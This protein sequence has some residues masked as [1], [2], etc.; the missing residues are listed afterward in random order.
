MSSDIA[1]PRVLTVR[2]VVS[3]TSDATAPAGHGHSARRMNMT[4]PRT[5][6]IARLA[7]PTFD[8]SR[9]MLSIS[10]SK[11]RALSVGGASPAADMAEKNQV[12]TPRATTRIEGLR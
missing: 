12:P 4:T 5:S 10:E 11:G 6:R 7:L 8:V 2:M 9:M 1:N 3:A